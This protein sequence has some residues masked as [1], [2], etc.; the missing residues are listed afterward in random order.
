MRSRNATIASTLLPVPSSVTICPL[1]LLAD[2][3]QGHHTLGRPGCAD[4]PGLQPQGCEI[5][6]VDRLALG[7]HHPLEGGVARLGD[8]GG[9]GQQRRELRLEH[10][11]GA[12]D[13]AMHGD[14][15]ALHR[16]LAGEGELGQIQQLSQHAGHHPGVGIGGLDGADHQIRLLAPDHGG[17]GAGRGPG[18]RPGQGL[19]GDEDRAVGTHRHGTPQ[20]IGRGR[21]AHADH[22]DLTAVLLHQTQRRLD[23]VLIGGIEDRLVRVAHQTVG[24][25]IHLHRQVGVRHLL[26]RDTDLHSSRRV[27]P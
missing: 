9:D 17:Q 20:G 15:L 1:F 3:L 19:V 11:R 14:R 27:L 22:H 4:C 13:V 8:A 23:A 26:D 12:L 21:R 10:L 24:G 2:L 5:P 7:S 16:H 18:I 6:L 25:R